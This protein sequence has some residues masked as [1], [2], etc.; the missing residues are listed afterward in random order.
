M[1]N[2]CCSHQN[3][4]H[5]LHLS[6]MKQLQDEQLW[7]DVRCLSYT[8]CESQFRPSQRQ[9][10]PALIISTVFEKYLKG[11]LLSAISVDAMLLFKTKKQTKNLPPQKK[12]TKKIHLEPIKQLNSHYPERQQNT[13]YYS[14]HLTAGVSWFLPCSEENDGAT[15]FNISDI[16]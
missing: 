11:R 2:P 13:R 6:F 1:F 9:E 4:C 15:L 7:L 5:F 3:C 10:D 16:E 12:K 8:L 14:C